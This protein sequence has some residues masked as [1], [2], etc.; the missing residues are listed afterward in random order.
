MTWFDNI[1]TAKKTDVFPESSWTAQLQKY[2]EYL[3]YWTGEVW[4]TLAENIQVE[5][6][7]KPLRWPVKVNLI[8]LLVC[9]HAMALWGEWDDKIIDFRAE[10]KPE[11]EIEKPGS[12]TKE[13][14]VKRL[15]QET[16]ELLGAVWRE[17]NRET[18]CIEQSVAQSLYGGCAFAL[19]RDHS[20]KHEIRIAY[21]S[22]YYFQPIWH[23]TDFHTLLEARIRFVISAE[24]ARLVYGDEYASGVEVAVKESWNLEE[25]KIEVGGK[26]YANE[27]NPYGVIPVVYVPRLRM[28]EYYGLSICEDLMGLQDEFNDRIADIGDQILSECHAILSLINYRGNVDDLRPSPTGIINLGMQAP[29]YG[30]P[31]LDRIPAG[32]IPKGA[33]DHLNF[34]LDTAKMSAFTPPV[35]F[36][37]DEGSQRSGLTLIIRMWPLL[38]QAKWLR[39]WWDDGFRDINNIILS[40][41]EAHEYRGFKESY[42]GHWIKPQWAPVQPKDRE[43]LVQELVQLASADLQSLEV[44]VDRLGDAEDKEA[45]LARIKAWI[46]M[47]RRTDGQEENRVAQQA[48]PQRGGT[49]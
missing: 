20:K 13:K 42:K 26:E 48:Q 2:D 1:V 3:K 35:A 8:K 44:M 22:P 16:Q 15:A 40:M 10:P 28:E 32:E 23:P 31:A 7:Q 17:N 25:H 46:A 9:M 30:P 12:I 21:L 6:G 43:A 34:L 33:F 14:A 4:E 29:G 45:E 39:A 19:S 36:G 41:L 47:K 18:L 27:E 11:A 5:S 37:Q 49:D 24:Q 38:Q